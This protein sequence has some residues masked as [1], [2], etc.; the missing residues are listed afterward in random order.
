V[1]WLCFVIQV[2]AGANLS[3]QVKEMLTTP[4]LSPSLATCS[5]ASE[6][7]TT[8][9]TFNGSLHVDDINA[10]VS[11]AVTLCKLGVNL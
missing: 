7:A 8:M 10:F 9:K 4:P 6:V 2:A 3:A 11:T 1:V 5:R